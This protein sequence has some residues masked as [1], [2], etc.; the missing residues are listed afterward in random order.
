MCLGC[1]MSERIH[2]THRLVFLLLLRLRCGDLLQYGFGARDL[3]QSMDTEPSQHPHCFAVGEAAA[4]L[5]VL[6]VG[7]VTRLDADDEDRGYHERR[8][9]DN[10]GENQDDR[11]PVPPPIAQAVSCDVLHG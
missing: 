4:G 5:L 9:N 10:Y 7:G 2:R 11:F 8:E 6:R 3:G 1:E